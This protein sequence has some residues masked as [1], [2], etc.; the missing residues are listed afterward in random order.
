MLQARLRCDENSGYSRCESGECE[1]GIG[2][3]RHEFGD[4]AAEVLTALYIKD[5]LLRRLK[6]TSMNC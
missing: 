3:C 4:S 6:V 2:L 5:W 1:D